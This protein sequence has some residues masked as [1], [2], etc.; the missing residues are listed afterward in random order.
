[1]AYSPA[2]A[3]P[4]PGGPGSSMANSLHSRGRSASPPAGAPLS[5]RD[6]RRSALQERLQDLTASFSQNRDTQ[7][8]QQ[9]HALQCDMTLIN[10]ADPYSPGPLPDSAEEIAQLIESTVGGG[11]FAKEMS[12]L[13]GMWYSRFV[14]EV[15]Q[16]KAER[17]TELAMLRHRHTSNLDRFEKEFAFRVHFA[18]EEYDNLTDTLRERLVQTISGKRTRLMR[19][20]EQLDIADTNALLLHPNQFSI[21]NPSSP[22]G[23][24]GNRKT[25]HTRHRVDLDELGNGILAE[26]FNKRKRKA[27]EED[28]GSPVRE[29]GHSNPAERAKAQVAQQQHAPSYSIQSLF[30]EKELS[31]HAN[32]AHVATVHFF[33]TSKRADQPSGTAT[34]G[35]NTDAEDASGADGTEDNGT[36][37]TDMARIASQNFHATRSTRTHG[38]H[39]LNPLSELSDKPAVRPNLPYNIL[40]NYHARPSNNG[41]PPLPPLMNEEVDDDWARMDRLQAKPAGFVDRGLIQLLV[42]RKDDDDDEPKGTRT[43][44]NPHQFS[45]LH[46]DFP[47]D[48]GI[49]LYPIESG[50]TRPEYKKTR[51]G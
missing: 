4:V 42:E 18:Q 45:M 24:H 19:E 7:F 13:A 28:V 25:R 22:G 41:A 47:P 43:P 31:A 5:K 35:N 2:P 11:K 12:S 20:K 21:T 27:P 39:A 46:P 15:N 1:M 34:N 8:R 38:N 14:Q 32:Q 36:P 29:S 40:A 37:A 50:R 48:M 26:H 33:S 49:H 9:L 10:N 23:I 16:V 3:S 44:D 30:T 17:D 51:T 6:K